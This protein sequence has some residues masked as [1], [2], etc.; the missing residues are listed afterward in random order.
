MQ[1]VACQMQNDRLSVNA[2]THRPDEADLQTR[3]SLPCLQRQQTSIHVCSVFLCSCFLLLLVL[4]ILDENAVI[5]HGHSVKGIERVVQGS[6]NANKT[7]RDPA[8]E[9][10]KCDLV[11]TRISYVLCTSLSFWVCCTIVT[12]KGI[13]L[14]S[15]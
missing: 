4:A 11:S 1:H 12:R 14:Q 10:T 6:E 9:E 3:S 7:S 13:F 2:T 15:L 8:V 5:I